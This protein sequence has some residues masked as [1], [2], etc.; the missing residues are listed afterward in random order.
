M[1]RQRVAIDGRNDANGRS[2]KQLDIK[3]CLQLL[4]ALAKGWLRQVQGLGGSS[5]AA[6]L[7][8]A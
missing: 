8:D 3:G 1:P 5:E 2:F 6:V 7:V 4:Y